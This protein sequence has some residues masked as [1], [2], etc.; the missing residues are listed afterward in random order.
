[1]KYLLTLS[2]K[3][4]GIMLGVLMLGGVEKVFSQNDLDI[5]R[6]YDTQQ[7]YINPTAP[8][9]W[10][11]IKYGDAEMNL[12]TGAIGVDIPVY[13]FKNK[14]F[15]LPISL[16]YASTG[17]KPNVQTGI[18][19]AGWYLNAGGVITREV[20]G[21][22]DEATSEYVYKDKFAG[23]NSKFG[24]KTYRMAGYCL[25][26]PSVSTKYD[27]EF[28]YSGAPGQEYVIAY[29]NP[30]SEEC[31]ETEP[32]LFHFNFMGYSGSFMFQPN[33][34]V[35][36]DC[37]TP[38]GELSVSGDELLGGFTIS[39]GDG[40]DYYFSKSDS[41]LS[42]D[43]EASDDG[44]EVTSNWTLQTI[45]APNGESVTFEYDSDM[46][47]HYSF[48]CI[49]NLFYETNY[50][51]TKKYVSE[52]EYNDPDPSTLTRQQG[53]NVN[54]VYT[55]S[56]RKI[57]VS[58][59]VEIEFEYGTKASE[60]WDNSIISSYGYNTD[61]NKTRRLDRIT[62]KNLYTNET[63]KTCQL[64]YN[65]NRND[66][67]APEQILTFLTSVE[68]SG[69]GV[70]SMEY[71]DQN[72]KCAPINTFAIDWWGYFNNQTGNND[73]SGNLSFSRFYPNH[74]KGVI[75]SSY[76]ARNPDFESAQYGML[77]RISYPTGG[78]SAFFYEQ[79]TYSKK[80]VRDNAHTYVPLLQNE[81]GKTGGV[82]IAS[83]IDHPSCDG[84]PSVYRDFIYEASLGVSSGI[85]VWE[86]QVY[87]K[88][89]LNPV[90]GYD[91]SREYTTTR[92]SFPYSTANHIEYSKVI[93][94]RYLS[95]SPNNISRTEHCFYT[96]QEY[97][98]Q[99]N[100]SDYRWA[101]SNE[102]SMHSQPDLSISNIRFL[103]CQVF[104]RANLRGKPKSKTFYSD[105][106]YYKESYAYTEV[107]STENSYITVPTSMLCQVSA[108][109]INTSSAFSRSVAQ[110]YYA[111]DTER[112]ETN[113][114]NS[115]NSRGQL[116]E[117]SQK[118]SKGNTR[119]K[120]IVYA[121]D[122][123][124][125]PA[126]I[127]YPVEETVYLKKSDNTVETISSVKC[128]YTSVNDHN[129][130]RSIP[131]LLSLY[132]GEITS[133]VCPDSISYYQ[134]FHNNAFDTHGNVVQA[135][136][137]GGVTS[138][139]VWGYGGSYVLAKIDNSTLAQVVSAL[140]HDVTTGPL[141][142]GLSDAQ[143]SALH[144]I[145]GTLVTTYD[146]KP[147]TGLTEIN[148]PSARKS[149][150]RYDQNNRLV[151]VDDDKGLPV[152]QYKYHI[153]TGK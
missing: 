21:I 119:I 31:Y 57:R 88:Y 4:P 150:F 80:V 66:N 48:S 144:A 77:K 30:D 81:T 16:N 5:T 82:R 53:I 62:V 139:Y 76:S 73:I 132:R 86:P 114:I 37:N 133:G 93:E 8:E 127:S 59:E 138:C 141:P 135:T 102:Y 94:K 68:L 60:I 118:D 36:F 74:Y 63:I 134:E 33:G 17:Y 116:T 12:Y 55:H 136:E 89:N 124:M 27:K 2:K 14:N 7:G 117:V 61:G 15:T 79:N 100:P 25:A 104:S 64:N 46:Q 58:G 11:M 96:S 99:F 19:G 42:Y 23:Y 97:L 70:Y 106:G 35:V 52:D 20:N 120:R 98:D 152:S 149:F 122:V 47:C 113:T 26:S 105:S 130:E 3:L 9:A 108:Q 39:T 145:S 85:L 95:K 153:V 34:I 22:P 49:P 146:Y 151:G 129:N 112:L 90:T 115:Y 43:F 142:A 18:L 71:Y 41:S 110:V 103:Y 10:S 38:P 1:M 87:M 111:G 29:M 75:S 32:D 91:I 6:F 45:H 125:S 28:L 143:K 148:D 67:A 51:R 78:S 131:C 109:R 56:L 107:N 128:N 54:M 147:L 65:Y 140:G 24:N 101:W 13:T 40:Y 44:R 84:M 69:E 92:Q 72:R 50:T 83:V 123:V 126:P 137:K 121:G